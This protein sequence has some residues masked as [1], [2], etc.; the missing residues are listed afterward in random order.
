M[1]AEA[2][3]HCHCQETGLLTATAYEALKIAAQMNRMPLCGSC[4][5]G[6]P[7]S[8]AARQSGAG[9]MRRLEILEGTR[10]PFG[11][12]CDAGRELRDGYQLA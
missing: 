11:L 8:S 7:F 1:K 2:V 6:V 12:P 5:C 3:R 10:A 9:A 4:E